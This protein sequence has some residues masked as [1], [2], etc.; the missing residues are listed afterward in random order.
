MEDYLKVLDGVDEGIVVLDKDLNI[1]FWNKYM[2]NITDLSRDEVEEKYICEVLPKFKE[3]IFLDIFKY[4]L[5]SNQKYFFSAALHK[6]FVDIKRYGN[7]NLR[8]NLKLSTISVNDENHILMEF[9]DVTGQYIRVEELKSYIQRLEETQEIIKNLADYDQLTN[10]YN[11]RV[12][13]EE[14]EELIEKNR[15]TDF[16]GVFT[17]L[18]VD[19]FKEIND[20]Y[21]H[22]FG[23]EVL[24]ITG[25][26]LNR[27][28]RDGDLVGRYGGD[29]FLIF[30]P[31]VKERK[32]MRKLSQRIL[33]SLNSPVVVEGKIIKPSV[34][35]G[36]SLYPEDGT[37]IDELFRVADKE[38]YRDKGRNERCCFK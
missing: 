34:S 22:Y 11:R 35:L 19:K 13:F 4:M 30:V 8:Q 18:D 12:F 33:D 17:V 21:G 16:R 5:K 36:M 6:K 20:T 37:N 26:R 25:E 29:E 32:D 23:D 3:K 9:V 7:C 38:L 10:V 15:E 14:V 31:N 1:V 27:I 24:R 28:T 2:E